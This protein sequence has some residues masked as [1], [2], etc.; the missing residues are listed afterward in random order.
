MN[1][2]AALIAVM[3][4]TLT[5][6][7]GCNKDKAKDQPQGQ[8]TNLA[9]NPAN[10]QVKEDLVKYS[11]A[12]N[13]IMKPLEAIGGLTEELAKAKTAKAYVAKLRK[14]FVPLV[15]E[16]LTQIEALKPSTKEVQDIHSAY[17]ASFRDY[18]AGLTEMADA[19]EKSDDKLVKIAED[20]INA[21]K[22]AYAKYAKDSSELAQK[23]NIKIM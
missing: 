11:S 18:A 13:K 9:A 15:T 17:L 16:A 12:V 8:V 1:K 2:H 14:E 23:N 7:G 4:G 10:D 22:P 19:V 6:A 21:F 3:I 5:I 20:K